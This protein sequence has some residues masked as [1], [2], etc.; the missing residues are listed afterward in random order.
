MEK[1]FA[2]GVSALG[3]SLKKG[4]LTVNE[5]EAK[6]VRLI[7]DLYLSGMGIHLIKKEL[8]S[9][10][11]L[12]PSG[13]PR[14]STASILIILKNEKYVGVLKQKKTLTIDYLSHKRKANEGEEKYVVVEN[15]HPPIVDKEIFDRTQAELQRRKAATFEKS[16]Y[17]NRYVWSGKIECAVC[18]SKFERRH[19]ERKPNP[20]KIVWQ[21]SEAVKYGR[22]KI[23]AQGQ[24]VGCNNKSVHEEFLKEN[25]LAVLNTVIENKDLVV[26]E[27][28]TAVQHVIARSPNNADE[29]RAITASVERLILRK[30]KLVDTYVDGLITR[31]EFEEAKSR[32]SKQLDLLEKQLLSLKHGNE[33]IETL[34]QKLANVETA[35]E[36]LARLKEFG[37]SICSELLHKV[38]VDGREKIS[39]Y[40]KTNENADMFVKMPVSFS[41]YCH[42]K[43]Q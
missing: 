30:S 17:S 42:C 23:N 11:I 27:L 29:M 34:Q 40:L 4:K 15:N 1:G 6:I 41:Q 8:E 16:R 22:E 28:K 14:W 31:A 7:F 18:K 43:Q 3:Y 38:V 19:N 36:N 24:K 9:R 25:F 21:C 39:V 12:S 35:I 20:P 26:R 13:S 37:D 32:Y 5:D 33:T 2:F 10:G